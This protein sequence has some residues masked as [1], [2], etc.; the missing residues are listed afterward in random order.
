M[1]ILADFRKNNP[2]GDSLVTRIYQEYLLKNLGLREQQAWPILQEWNRKN[3][4]RCRS[5][6]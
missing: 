4:H 6:N 2:C 1:F 5:M 3:R